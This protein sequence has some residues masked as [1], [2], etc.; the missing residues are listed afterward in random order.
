[1][2]FGVMGRVGLKMCSVGE[3][4]DRT[5]G[6]GN[7][8]GGYGIWVAHYKQWRI[9]CMAVENVCSD[10]AAKEVVSG[11]GLNQGVLARVQIASGQVAVLGVFDAYSLL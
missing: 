3:G 9:C 5:T 1:M 2:L 7:F 11:A 6:M 10:Q 4:A 8:G